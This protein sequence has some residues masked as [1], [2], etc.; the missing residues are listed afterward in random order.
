M[1]IEII[2]NKKFWKKKGNYRKYTNDSKGLLKLE[3]L[4]KDKTIDK[5][6]RYKA[7]ELDI[8]HRL[9]LLA[10]LKVS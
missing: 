1:S 8:E 7:I 3:Q 5:R 2:K 6:E 4:I 10:N 9:S